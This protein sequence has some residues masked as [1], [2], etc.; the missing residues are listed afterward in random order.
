MNS[1][2][3]T[4]IAQGVHALD[5]AA[6]SLLE[7]PLFSVVDD[8]LIEVMQDIEAITRKLDAMKQHLVLEAVT[9][10]LPVRAGVKSPVRFLQETLRLS[11]GEAAARV[12]NTELLSEVSEGTFTRPPVLALVAQAQRAG[13]ISTDHIR[14]IHE[15]IKQI[16]AAA[17]AKAVDFAEEQL[18]AFA[19]EGDPKG[20]TTLGVRILQFTDPDG[21]LTRDRDQQARRGF[22][23]GHARADGMA[24]VSGW[25][26]P[27]F[28]AVFTP[29]LEKLARPGMCNPDDPQS[30]WSAAELGIDTATDT[31]DQNSDGP[32]AAARAVLEAAAKRD[33]RTAAQRN[34]DAVIAFLRPDMGPTRLG[35]HRGLP[36]STVITMSITDLEQRT[37]MATTA[38]GGTL[39]IAQAVELAANAT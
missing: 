8:E 15:V 32:V 37:G 18:T 20:I 23:I 25:V 7:S 16:P 26:T 4:A 3:M 28:Q 38:T 11:P 1:G 33:H 31:G 29:V 13:E 19:R 21:S 34:H 30:P 35:N 36:V 2:G 22:T 24:P 9:R 14:A 10:G 6:E 39:S 17:G 5:V 27:Q 12:R